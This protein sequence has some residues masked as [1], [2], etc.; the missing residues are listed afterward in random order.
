[1]AHSRRSPV[2]KY[3]DRVASRYDHMYG[4]VFWQWHDALTWDYLKP[5]LPKDLRAPIVDLGCGTGK[6]A[7]K[8]RKSGY[9]VTCVDV[10]P[11]MLDQARAKME[12]QPASAQAEFIQADLVDLSALPQ[13]HFALAI[14]LGEPIGFAESPRR[15]LGQIRR[16]LAAGGML[17]ATVDNRLAGLDFFIT[18]RDP[19]A[20]AQFLRDGK[21]HWLTKDRSEQFPIATFGPKEATKVFES[22]GF[23]VLELIGK[24][25]LP[26]RKHRELLESPESRRKW[27]RLEKK[28][29]RDPYAIGLASHLQLSCLAIEG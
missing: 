8:L 12:S 23:Q 28:L 27:A 6:W 2:R 18:Q 25:V 21:T 20:L 11:N 3:H 10:S 19:N 29:C 4:D 17:V 16:I 13:D 24:T 15:A 26:M 5:F 1:M 14:A 9:A 22:A 7:T